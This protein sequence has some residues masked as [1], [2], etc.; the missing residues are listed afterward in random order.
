MTSRPTPANKEEKE[1]LLAAVGTVSHALYFNNRNQLADLP[2]MKIIHNFQTKF[3]R[4][5][6]T[7]KPVLR[8]L[9]P[10]TTKMS[11]YLKVMTA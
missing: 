7:N 10:K 3:P 9:P 8:I 2:L 5:T 4:I 1:A 6:T 11:C